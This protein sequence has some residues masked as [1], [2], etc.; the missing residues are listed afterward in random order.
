[1]RH[2]EG[3]NTVFIKVGAGVLSFVYD[4]SQLREWETD[5][6]YIEDGLD[7]GISGGRPGL[8]VLPA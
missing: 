5:D 2:I 4:V 8:V 6:G 1:M 3:D 7:S